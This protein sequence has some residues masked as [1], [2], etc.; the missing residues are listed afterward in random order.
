[1]QPQSQQLPN[2]SQGSPFEQLLMEH[3]LQPVQARGAVGS[4]SQ[5][6]RDHHLYILRS[7]EFYILLS[8]FFLLSKPF[9]EILELSNLK[10]PDDKHAL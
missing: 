6:R 7:G 9:K 8:Y 1:M 2:S 4:W 10:S 5:A 3:L